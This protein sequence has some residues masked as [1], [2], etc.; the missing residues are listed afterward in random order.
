M[1]VPKIRIAGGQKQRTDLEGPPSRKQDSGMN[2]ISNIHTKTLDYSR[3]FIFFGIST[4]K[5]ND[6][7]WYRILNSFKKNSK[8]R[9]NILVFQ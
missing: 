9:K 2:K 5:F 1:P 7:L 4:R 6:I 8:I 3:V